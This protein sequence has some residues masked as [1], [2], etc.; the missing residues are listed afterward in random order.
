VYGYITLLI[1]S[2][3]QDVAPIYCPS[4]LQ[5][6]FTI[7]PQTSWIS[8]IFSG[9]QSKTS[10][11]EVNARLRLTSSAVTSRLTDFF[12][13]Y[14]KTDIRMQSPSDI[15]VTVAIICPFCYNGFWGNAFVVPGNTYATVY[16]YNR[17]YF[18][19]KGLRC[20]WGNVSSGFQQVTI[21]LTVRIIKSLGLTELR[22]PHLSYCFLL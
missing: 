15:S 16:C 13:G 19:G 5:S 6:H 20:F 17:G 9:V 2:L 14:F 11:F 18:L 12:G 3:C 8:T 21:L 10:F 4:I 22:L 1:S 7:I